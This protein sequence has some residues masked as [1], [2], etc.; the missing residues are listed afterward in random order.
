MP[1]V[2]ALDVVMAFTL[3]LMVYHQYRVGAPLLLLGMADAQTQPRVQATWRFMTGV[4]AVIA[5]IGNL[6][7][8]AE[9]F[10]FRVWSS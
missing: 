6:I 4:C 2:T 7:L 8:W 9:L 1:H 3:M 10:Y 5:L